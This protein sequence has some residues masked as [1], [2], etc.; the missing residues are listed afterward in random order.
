MGQAHDSRRLRRGFKPYPPKGT[1]KRAFL[2]LMCRPQGATS[3]EL[4]AILSNAKRVFAVID[5]LQKECGLDIR[6]MKGTEGKIFKVIG[7]R[8]PSGGYRTFANWLEFLDKNRTS[9]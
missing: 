4:T 3:R 2:M 5:S 8:K 6:F 9:M 7:Q 1:T